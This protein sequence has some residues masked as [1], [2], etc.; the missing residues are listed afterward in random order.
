M[1]CLIYT[2]T[3]VTNNNEDTKV[4]SDLFFIS[5]RADLSLLLVLGNGLYLVV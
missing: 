1:I 2:H 4:Y 5:G 3:R